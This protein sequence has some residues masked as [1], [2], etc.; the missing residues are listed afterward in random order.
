M[1]LNLYSFR[2]FSAIFIT[3]VVIKIMDDYID[4]GDNRCC[5]LI[6]DMGNGVLPYTII[7]CCF[8]IVLDKDTSIT[9]I[10]SAY[11]VGMFNDLKR[12]LSLGL[13]GYQEIL[14]TSLV[15]IMFL[16]TSEFVSSFIII[17]LIQLIDDLIDYKR[18]SFY[19]SHNFVSKF[20]KIEVILLI[21]I[22]FL[23]LVK[24]VAFKMLLSLVA[25][26][27]IQVI[28]HKRKWRGSNGCLS[29]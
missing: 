12:P 21:I 22:L 26:G 17:V 7:L 24:V 8:A 1:L 23:L 29:N 10:V 5:K 9:L 19:G 20:G 18:D 3:G 4:G 28:E 14:A 15:C 6:Q 11:V 2:L 27:L 13:N 16:G 25:F